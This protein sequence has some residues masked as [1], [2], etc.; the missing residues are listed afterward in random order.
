MN[1]IKVD[2][3]T[4]AALSPSTSA[5]PM[6]ITNDPETPSNMKSKLNPAVAAFAPTHSSGKE[7]ANSGSAQT[8][9]PTKDESKPSVAATDPKEGGFI[10]P[11]LR[12]IHNTS[13]GMKDNVQVTPTPD[14]FVKPDPGLQAW[15]DNQENAPSN[16][17][18]SQELTATIKD[19]LIDIDPY[20][21][22]KGNKKAAILP[23]GFIPFSTNDGAPAMTQDAVTEPKASAAA[24]TEKERNAAFLAQYTKAIDTVYAKYSRDA[25]RNSSSEEKANETDPFQ[26]DPV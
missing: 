17:A 14:T 22:E 7:S 16:D 25:S 6:T 15:L 18:S 5:I 9:S 4:K 11:H 19:T 21:P 2:N 23:P 1:V 3:N 20:S 8:S 26:T 24:A 12:R 10:P 13:T